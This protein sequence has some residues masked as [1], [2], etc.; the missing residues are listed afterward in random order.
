MQSKTGFTEV[1]DEKITESDDDFD[2]KLA[3]LL[4]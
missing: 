4:L 1:N 3:R 2:L